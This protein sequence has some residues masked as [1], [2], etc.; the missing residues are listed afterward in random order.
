MNRHRSTLVERCNDN[1]LDETTI[2]EK[3]KSQK[4]YEGRH[5]AQDSAG[6]DFLPTSSK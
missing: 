3:K 5:G 6:C 1:C 2:E 4:E